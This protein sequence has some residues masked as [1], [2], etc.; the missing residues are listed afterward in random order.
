MRLRAVIIEGWRRFGNWIPGDI[1]R[2][3]GR[4]GHDEVEIKLPVPDIAV[5]R[6]RLGQMGAQRLGRVHERNVLFDTPDAALRRAGK[7]LRLRWNNRSAVLTFKRR[8]ARKRGAA[9]RF[10]VR[11]EI[12]FP[13]DG[14]KVAAV[15]A[16]IGFVPGFRYEKY[17]T[18]YR[19]AGAT[20]VKLELDETPIGCFLELEGAPAAIDR[21]ARR[22]GY[23]AGDYIT[24][25]YLM[26]FRE[27]C[28]TKGLR[29]AHMLFPRHEKTGRL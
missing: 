18:S 4:A 1:L 21:L 9:A 2:A 22:L 15:L 12:E 20:H 14:G 10:K 29:A 17:R 5:L 26:L 19:V 3:M 25:N 24:A 23:A 28:R 7:L 27:H 16:G 11:H 8:V 6:R 13:V